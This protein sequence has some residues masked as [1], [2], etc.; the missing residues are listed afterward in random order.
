MSG[1]PLRDSNR[2][3][4]PIGSPSSLSGRV[5]SCFTIRAIARLLFDATD[6]LLGAS[7]QQALH[8]VLAVHIAGLTIG[9]CVSGLRR[10]SPDRVYS[11]LS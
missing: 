5:R 8:E 1:P 4:F 11:L 6:A 10:P 3:R 9:P 7:R 2:L